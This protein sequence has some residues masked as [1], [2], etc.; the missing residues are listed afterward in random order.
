[1]FNC[2]IGTWN[3]RV[4]ITDHEKV[5][6]SYIHRRDEGELWSLNFEGRMFCCWKCGSGEHIG[7]KCRQQTKTF[8]E[9]FNGSASDDSFV[10]PTWAAV[11]RSG[12]G[13]SND[14]KQRVAD[15]EAK[16]KEDNKNKKQH[17]RMAQRE[18]VRVEKLSIDAIKEAENNAALFAEQQLADEQAEDADLAAL[19]DIVDPSNVNAEHRG[20]STF[21]SEQTIVKERATMNPSSEDKSDLVAELDDRDKDLEYV[22]GPGAA[23]LAEQY[24][25]EALLPDEIQGGDRSNISGSS[26]DS[27]RLGGNIKVASTPRTKSRGRTRLRDSGRSS[28]SSPSPVRPRLDSDLIDPDPDGLTGSCRKGDD[29]SKQGNSDKVRDGEVIIHKKG[30]SEKHVDD[31]G[32]QVKAS[33]GLEISSAQD[34]A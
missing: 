2:Y 20:Q 11:V 15:M 21:V 14:L 22:F 3:V 28:I 31:T 30:D 32:L 19:A 1:M 34:N 24:H 10:Q 16:V 26:G 27:S 23:A 4:K 8:D 25:K 33:E 17:Q 9:V 7:D 5:I 13:L 12:Q 18:A 29:I 6:P